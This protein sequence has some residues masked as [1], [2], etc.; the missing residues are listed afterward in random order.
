M[1]RLQRL[2]ARARGEERGL[3]LSEL[4]IAMSLSVLILTI[5]GSFLVSSQ[6]A[7]K[8]ASSVSG[9]TR[10]AA[11]VMNE[12][13]RNLRAATDNPVPTG[14]DSQ[15]AFQYASATSVRFFA[16]VNLDSSLSQAVE[17]QVTL[18]TTRKV[19]TETK[20]NGAAVAGN[21]SYYSFPLATGSL[22]SAAPS[23]TRTL[24]T[25]VTSTSL[26]AFADAADTPLSSLTTPVAAVD[27]PD[28]RSV[29]VSVTIGASATDP[30][31]VSLTNT[32]SM[33]NIVMGASS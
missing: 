8:V 13:G 21:S 17:V 25:S 23:S 12:V 18:D 14:D 20:W 28:I 1:T 29:D 2:L 22:L 32:A 33:P 5:A 9:N 19:I 26:F 10:V 6:K 16:Y 4:I 31:A 30:N 3:T 24:A 11:N 15:F 27:L 7:A